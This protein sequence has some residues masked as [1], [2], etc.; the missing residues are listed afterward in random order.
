MQ[1]A[2]AISIYAAIRLRHLAVF[3]LGRLLSAFL[4]KAFP[5]MYA[6]Q[7]RSNRQ[8]L[9]AFIAEIRPLLHV[10]NYGQ[11]YTVCLLSGNTSVLCISCIHTCRFE[12]L[13]SNLLSRT[14]Q[15]CKDCMKDA[16]VSA[17]D[18]TEVL[19]VGGM[20]RMPKVGYLSIYSEDCIQGVHPI[21]FNHAN[22]NVP[23][24]RAM[25]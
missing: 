25:S 5:F 12:S 7:Y 2:N 8:Q 13:V 14:Q 10:L 16:G 4:R 20:T 17:S 23:W 19:L 11:I 18:I 15:P 24:K 9:A 6:E 1:K 3:R 21:G 22:H